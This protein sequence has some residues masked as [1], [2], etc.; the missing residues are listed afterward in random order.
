VFITGA[1]GFI[2]NKLTQK[3]I[4]EGAE[5]CCF[6]EGVDFSKPFYKNRALDTRPVKVVYGD[7]RDIKAVGQSI[8]QFRPALIFHLAAMSQ[9]TDAKDMPL[10]AFDINIM[11]TAFVCAIA[12]GL[13]IPVMV[14]SSD[15]AY[16]D[17]NGATLCEG[18]PLDPVH[19]YDVSKGAADLIARCFNQFYGQPVWITRCANVWGPGDVNWQRLI[20]ECIRAVLEKRPIQ[21]RSDGS[22]VREYIYVDDV[23][24]AYIRAGQ[25]LVQGRKI[26]YPAFNISSGMHD[27]V[28]SIVVA[29]LATMGELKHTVVWGDP[30]LPEGKATLLDGSWFRNAFGWEPKVNFDDGI[31]RT[32]AWMKGYLNV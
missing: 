31:R 13:G 21:I 23:V 8:T 4:Q 19:P 2:G 16:G 25:H 6:S 30:D 14:A 22:L 12:A 27:D 10:A 11:G 9:V 24:D 26:A 20:P 28:R 32:A 7:I 17:W 29:I 15:K 1:D 18:D 3:L 5:P